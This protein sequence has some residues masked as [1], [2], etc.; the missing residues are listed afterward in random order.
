M[1]V[2]PET[3]ALLDV[4]ITPHRSLGRQGQWIALGIM[5]A[6]SFAVAALF[7]SRGYWPVAPF[8]GLDVALLA[9]AFHAARR[10]ARAFEDVRISDGEILIRR[11][12]GDEVHEELRLPALWT[13]LERDDHP[14][15]GCVALRLAR[16]DAATPVAALLPPSERATFA[17]A[18]AQA[19]DR[20]RRGG[21]AAHAPICSPTHLQGSPS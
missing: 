18:L 12:V 4:H 16:R 6:A 5:A 19:L 7:V 17:E 9:F 13:R 11:G 10:S 14:D 20:A 21:L 3:A 2:A 1:S 8:I 15:F